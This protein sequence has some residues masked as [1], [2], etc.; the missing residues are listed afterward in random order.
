MAERILFVAEELKLNIG[1]QTIF[2]NASMSIYEGERVALIGR[3]GCGKSTLLRIISGT[4]Q[5]GEGILSPMRGLRTAMME[6]DFEPDPALTVRQIASAGLTFFEKLLKRYEDKNIPLA[7]HEEIEHFLT[8]HNAWNPEVKLGETLERLSLAHLADRTAAS[9]SG[10]EKRRA[11][12]AGAIAGA[13]DLLLLDEPTNHLDINTVEWLEEFLAS[14]RGSVLFV[15]HDRFFLDR[16]ATRIL[17]LDH[18]KF[19]SY[20]GSY[21]DYLAAKADREAAEDIAESKRRKFLRA[22]IEWV[23]RSPKARLRRNLG[24]LKNFEAVAARSAPERTGD[25]D[26]VIPPAPRLGNQTV[27]LKELAMK[28]GDGKTLFENFS[29]EFAAGS[30]TGIVGANGIGKSSLLKIITGALKP[31]SG[32][33]K[34][35][36]TVQFNYIDQSRLALDPEKTVAEDVAGDSDTVYLGQ[37]K[38]S[39]RSYLRRF[40]FEDERINTKI[41]YL[42]GGEKARIV[43]AKILKQGGNFL[44]LD[45]PTN[46][47]DLSTLRLLEEALLNYGGCVLAVSHDR[48]FLNRIC[49][50]ILAFEGDGK[51]FYTPGDFDYYLSKREERFKPEKQPRPVKKSTPAAQP[52]KNTGKKLSYKETKELEGME[53]AIAQAEEKISGLEAMF[54]AP[55]F[56][57]VH[58]GRIN[59]LQ[60]ELSDAR[61]EAER[62]YIRWEELEKLAAAEIEH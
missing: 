4:E 61:A 1:R 31:T 3:N 33:V 52:V 13:P 30:K 28:Y 9:L 50:G 21:A 55:D 57:A 27:I 51:L 11:A 17:E 15:T 54:S 6:Q 2:D 39:V 26:L 25:I 47:L 37:E 49:D 5:P 41:K 8:L 58:G 12:L 32:E 34:T 36:P 60:Q 48:Y 53:D 7:E 35:A 10:G 45:E 62:L 22:E 24:R 14:Y 40:L 42:S 43:M 18:G 19:Y 56:F 23:R 38:I 59:E 29:F 44:I 46:D 20:T 16:I